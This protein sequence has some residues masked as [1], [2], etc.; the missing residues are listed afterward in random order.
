[1]IRSTQY[2]AAPA[3]TGAV[4]TILLSA[5]A[6]AAPI[7]DDLIG[8]SRGGADY[9]VKTFDPQVGVVEM[10]GGP[11]VPPV[12]MLHPAE[13]L[14][15][16]ADLEENRSRLVAEGKLS[17]SYEKTITT[18]GWPVRKAAGRT[19]FDFHG[20]GAF[21]DENPALGA[22]LDYNCGGR[23]YDLPG[24]NYNH[25]GTDIFNYPFA[26]KKMD[27]EDV[28]IA[29]GA[30]GTIILKQDGNTDR[31]CGFNSNPWNAVYVQHADGS[32]AWYGHMKNGSTTVKAVGETVAA[33]EYLGAVGSSG[34]SSG[35]HLHL[36]LY[37]ATNTLVDPWLG[38]CNTKS[39]QIT[40]A[41]QR[42]YRDTGVNAMTVGTAAPNFPT[43]PS[44]ESSFAT[45]YVTPLTTAY[46]AVYM[47]DQTAS[48]AVTIRVLRP[49]GSVHMGPRT[50]GTGDYNASFAYWSMGG[51]Q[52]IPGNWTFEATLAGKTYTKIFQV[53]GAAPFGAAASI[54]ALAGSAQ[55]TPPNAAFP[56]PVKVLVTDAQGRAVKGARV[57]FSTPLSGA[58][59]VLESRTAITDSAG[60]AAVAAIANA[61]AGIYNVTANV[62]GAA[63]PAV[64]VL[65]NSN[66]PIAPRLANI[67]T[68]M[69]V[70]TGNDVL[71]GGFIIGG[72]APKTVVV[73]ARGPSLVPLGVPNALANPLLQLF[74]GASQI[75]S[76]D[77]WTT[78][79]NAV[80]LNASGFAPPNP[81]ESAIYTTLTPGAYTAIVTGSGGGTGV[82][83]IEVF[84]VD[85]PDLPLAN[86]STR[87]QVMT[88]DDV[89]I[90]G[91]IIQGNSP[92]TVVVRARGPSLAA[93]G[94]PGVLA[95]PVLQLYS[96]QSVIASND[97]WGQAANAAQVSSS[98]FAPANAS[99]SAIL[100]TPNPG[101]YTAIVTG[102][103]GATG[104][105]IVEVFAQN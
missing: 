65:Q 82:G 27:D 64:V 46:F 15:I 4:F 33:G 60:V 75:A 103:N 25:K 68:R 102:K 49:D 7:L 80:L 24:S 47:R 95:N 66:A 73:R 38:A 90:G 6:F 99:E 91:F 56:A 11:F 52:A 34:S 2:P 35:P 59:T 18:F 13:R 21:V 70:L 12:D 76:N 19:D 63:S 54:V 85:R 79:S 16:L 40:F 22:L 42:A 36:E 5:S 89:M 78:A 57:S 48:T 58:T 88:N 41:Q 51:F 53:G 32:V 61:T 104:V 55:S 101:A 37:D 43:C 105:G 10:G 98:G 39:K 100:I 81:L 26:W 92:Q 86:I 94:V 8:P 84:E 3:V 44:P 9:R 71:I 72:N 31:S 23:T 96:G 93:Q 45:D 28:V 14:R 50:S 83:I 69:Q 20:I 97:D 30:P 67:S 62:P 87:G 77:N 1:M 17:R 29:A 74:S